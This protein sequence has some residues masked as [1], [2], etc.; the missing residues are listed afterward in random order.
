MRSIFFVAALGLLGCEAQVQSRP[1]YSTTQ[2]GYAE[3]TVVERNPRFRENWV[4]LADGYS[5]QTDRQFIN[6]RGREPLRKIRV[7]AVHG[8]PVINQ[9][10]IEYMDGNTQKVPINA[11]LPN[12]EAQVIDVNHGQPIN[13]I[14]VYAD[15]R[16][17]GS[18]SVFGT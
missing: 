4:T 15:P 2:P 6:L 9:I 3:P 18:Y 16:F 11:R 5:A 14:I 13:R 7:E 1:V 8:S 10:A 17:G 12:G